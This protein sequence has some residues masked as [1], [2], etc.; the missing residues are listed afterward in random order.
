M[1]KRFCLAL[2]CLFASALAWDCTTHT[3]ICDKA[4]INLDCCAADKSDFQKEHAKTSPYY[5]HCAD[6]SSNCLARSVADEYA[7]LPGDDSKAIAAHLYADSL[8]PAHWYS[9]NYDACHS[10]FESA[11]G[12]AIKAGTAGWRVEQECTNKKD[13][14]TVVL[15]ADLAYLDE[16]VQYVQA[17]LGTQGPV[18]DNQ[19]S[20][21]GRQTF[22]FNALL[23]S[24]YFA[25]FAL[26]AL[27]LGFLAFFA[28][29]GR[30]KRH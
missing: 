15:S 12:N 25:P 3:Y 23:N 21:N 17:K 28:Q 26:A 1:K 13:N 6:N 16:V 27:F 18:A 9:T 2:L 30:R 29:R 14:S 11:V 4:G 8:T 20:P 19:V 10:P 5:H 24:S 7:A 22:D